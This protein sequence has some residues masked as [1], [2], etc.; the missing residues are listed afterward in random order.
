M[1]EKKPP[2]YYVVLNTLKAYEQA[3]YASGKRKREADKR[4]RE[5]DKRKELQ[6]Q[7]N[8]KP[9]PDLD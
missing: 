7:T 9:L 4:K 8:A 6:E 3:N 2:I 5:T 1:T